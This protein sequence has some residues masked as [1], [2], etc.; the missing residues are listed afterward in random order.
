MATRYSRETITPEFARRLLRNNT[1]K[2][3]TPS[4]RNI[5]SLKYSM[6]HGSWNENA[7][8]QIVVT[9]DGTL[10]DGQNRLTALILAN[11]TYQFDV[12][13]VDSE[14]E[15]EY[16]DNSQQRRTGQ[17]LDAKDPNTAASITKAIC[18]FF[19]GTCGINES[20][21]G[22]LGNN[23]AAAPREMVIETYYANKVQIDKLVD[24]SRKIHRAIGSGSK[25]IYGAF[26]YLIMFIGEDESLD[27][28]VADICKPNSLSNSA[29]LLKQ[30]IPNLYLKN[31]RSHSGHEKTELE[32][33]K[34]LLFA[35]SKY[36]K[37]DHTTFIRPDSKVY[38]YYERKLK[39]KREEK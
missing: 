2:N 28:F 29:A 26:C 1:S 19:Y 33:L 39:E 15:F 8:N 23:R 20:M 24:I 4:Q 36:C 21:K 32:A 7:P 34:C 11:K 30:K 35:Y 38:N 5:A 17:F 10:L 13:T 12:A 37:G 16:I 31:A 25:K 3:R 6:E 22:I 14:K 9:E 27:S 18:G